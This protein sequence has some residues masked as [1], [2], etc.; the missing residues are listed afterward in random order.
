MSIIIKF[1]NPTLCQLLILIVLQ[2]KDKGQVYHHLGNAVRRGL[3]ADDAL[4]LSLEKTTLS[5]HAKQSMGCNSGKKMRIL[6]RF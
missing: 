1:R 3:K 4:Q 6:L 5:W 2:K